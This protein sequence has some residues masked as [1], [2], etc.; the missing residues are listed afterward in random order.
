MI[1][2]KVDALLSLMNIYVMITTRNLKFSLFDK[3]LTFLLIYFLRLFKNKGKKFVMDSSFLNKISFN[4][5]VSSCKIGIG[6]NI[7]LRAESIYTSF[8]FRFANRGRINFSSFCFILFIF[9]FSMLLFSI[10]L[11]CLIKFFELFFSYFSSFLIIGLSLL[12]SI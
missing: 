4:T 8:S 7:F 12:I 11:S 5:L 10:I 9:L 3:N 6:P 1:E 2:S